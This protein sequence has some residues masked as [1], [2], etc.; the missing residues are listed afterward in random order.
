MSF[1]VLKSSNAAFMP[2]ADIAQSP[3]LIIPQVSLAAELQSENNTR[4][5]GT[6][7]K[8]TRPVAQT[9]VGPFSEPTKEL[10]HPLSSE[11]YRLVLQ[12]HCLSCSETIR[13]SH[14]DVRS[15]LRRHRSDSNSPLAL[16]TINL[17]PSNAT[18]P[19]EAGPS[20]LHLRHHSSS[21]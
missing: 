5:S 17:L 2:S 3:F 20:L 21:T 14:R 10:S 11:P 12:W 19:S 7:A 13:S 18:I 15:S 6:G 16:R 8:W 4:K 1:E 9:M